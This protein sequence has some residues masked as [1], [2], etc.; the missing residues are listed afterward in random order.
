VR[1]LTPRVHHPGCTAVHTTQ[2]HTCNRCA[3]DNETVSDM[4]DRAPPKNQEGCLSKHEAGCKACICCS[5]H[6]LRAVCLH[7]S[8]RC[9][10][11]WS[12]VTCTF[13]PMERPT[14][15]YGS[16]L[17]HTG[18]NLCMYTWVPNVGEAQERTVQMHP[19]D[20]TSATSTNRTGL[21]P[22]LTGLKR[23]SAS[24]CL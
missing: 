9:G 1:R 6:E 14:A 19:G 11:L 16:Y 8:H 4:G 17:G 15:L 10:P 7:F 18:G 5:Q 3:A 12:A 22:S 2:Q 24:A 23:T 13:R 20:E 21:Q